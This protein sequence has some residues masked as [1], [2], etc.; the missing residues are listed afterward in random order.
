MRFNETL[1][2]HLRPFLKPSFLKMRSYEP[3]QDCSSCFMAKS[4]VYQGHLKCCTFFP[5]LVNF[6]VSGILQSELPGMKALRDRISKHKYAT[7]LGIVAPP[8]YQREFRFKSAEQFGNEE[9]LL[10]PYYYKGACSIWDWRSSEC[11]GF[12]CVSQ[13]GQEGQRAW[14]LLTKTLYDIE[15]FLGQEVMIEKGFHWNEVELCLEM[16]KNLEPAGQ[17]LGVLDSGLRT[18]WMH[19]SLAEEEWRAIWGHRFQDPLKYY[20]EVGRLIQGYSF[21][22]LSEELQKSIQAMTEVWEHVT[23]SHE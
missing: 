20:N 6:S 17:E 19:E 14:N 8:S 23:K 2:K 13:Y 22:S 16:I 15:C 21:S 18:H 1:P 9:G 3:Q 11:A 5:F 4:G 12:F 10:C 7:P